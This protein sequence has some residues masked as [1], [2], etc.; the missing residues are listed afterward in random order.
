[1]IVHMLFYLTS[2][3]TS[4][5]KGFFVSERS[6]NEINEFFFVYL[7]NSH[8][9]IIGKTFLVFSGPELVCSLFRHRGERTCVGRALARRFLNTL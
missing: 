1:M 4:L 7:G 9:H 8:S 2:M 5:M 3:H 6:L